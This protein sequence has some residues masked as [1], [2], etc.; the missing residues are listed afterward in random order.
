[1]FPRSPRLVSFPCFSTAPSR[2]LSSFPRKLRGNQLVW[3]QNQPKRQDIWVFCG[4]TWNPPGI[5]PISSVSPFRFCPRPALRLRRQG[6]SRVARMEYPLV[7]LE[8]SGNAKCWG[9]SRTLVSL[10]GFRK[11]GYRPTPLQ[12]RPWIAIARP[13]ESAYATRA[14]AYLEPRGARFSWDPGQSDALPHWA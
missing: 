7:S 4:Y 1:M 10:F 12:L 14:L 8:I 3:A 5:L 2:F 11:H 9:P 6:N 13:R